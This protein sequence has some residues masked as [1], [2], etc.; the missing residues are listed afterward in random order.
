MKYFIFFIFLTIQMIS[1]AGNLLN[2]E[3]GQQRSSIRS[4]GVPKSI[5]VLGKTLVLKEEKN[6]NN[7]FLAEYIP[8][9]EN[10]KNFT[11]MFALWGR[12]DGSTADSQVKA[13]V[14]F[15]NSRKG[16]DPVANYNL[17]QSNDKKMFG[18]DFLISEEGVMEHNVWA[19]QN[20]NGGVLAYQ[21]VRRYYVQNNSSGDENFIRGIPEIRNQILQFFKEAIL[22]RPK[23]YE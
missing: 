5:V 3:S 9:E 11:K 2:A 4:E 23:G 8:N 6:T 15:V 14:Q 10:F 19:F 17:F 12:L 21:Y 16:K 13:K 18:L 22:P 20:V 1:Q 7:Q